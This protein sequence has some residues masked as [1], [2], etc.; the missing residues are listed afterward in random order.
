MGLNSFG[1]A[2]TV[3]TTM[4][5]TANYSFDTAQLPTGNLLVGLLD[6]T[7]FG[8]GFTSL[9]FQITREGLTVED[10]TFTTAAAATTYFNDHVL[11]LG[12]L[13]TGVSGTLDLSFLL[14][15]NSLDDGSRFGTTF[16]IADIGVP[17]VPGDYNNNGVVDAADY[18]LWCKG[19]PLAN[20]VDMPGVVNSADYAAWRA[21]FGNTSG[22]GTGFASSA[23]AVPIPEPAA[24]I[25]FFVALA[26][27]IAVRGR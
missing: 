9:H 15:M 17:G 6:P 4:S 11:S 14:E 1:N 8:P 20:E 16:L 27:G 21:R 2:P 7:S 23:G 25:L 13:T 24:M 19:G 3:A 10:Q 26:C 5:T 22:S 18:V 12:S